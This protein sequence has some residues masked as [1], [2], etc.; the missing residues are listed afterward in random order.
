MEVSMADPALV[1]RPT[2]APVA[3]SRTD[4]IWFISA[5]TGWLVN[6][7]GNI[8]R[9]DD[10]G[11][12]WALQHHA[13][14]VYLRCVG[15]S[16]PQLGWVGSVSP[17]QRLFTT[18][19]GGAQWDVVG[20]LPPT[21]NKVCGLAVVDDQVIYGSGTNDPVDD[22]AILKT[23]DGGATWTSID[24][25]A[26][27][28]LLVDIH[29][30]TR[31]RGWVVGG[32]ADAAAAPA[33]QR[34]TRDMVRPVV[35]FTEDGG[36]TWTDLI[37]DK[38][39]FPHGEWGWKLF[40]LNDSVVFVSLENFR[41][42]AILKSIDGGKTWR[43]L[44]INDQQHNDNL[45]GVGFASD[46]I[47]WVGGWG[48]TSKTTNGG[49]NWA[50]AN[51]GQVGVHLNRFRFFGNPATL[52]YASGNTVYKYSAEPVTPVV[53]EAAAPSLLRRAQ[54]MAAGPAEH[55]IEIPPDAGSLS[56][57]LWD[58]FGNHLEVM[59]QEKP[60]AGEWKIRVDPQAAVTAGLR[61]GTGI[62]R[63]TI[64]ELTESTLMPLR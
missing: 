33:G 56:V 58:R 24:M 61:G 29:F 62:L 34:P 4:D 2:N 37:P 22:P 54:P 15:F 13:R 44:P 63:V 32:L 6:S 48:N 11:N 20:N 1:W 36:K 8:L 26:H 57:D 42:G 28:S 10:G 3:S 50:D 59:S 17:I 18:R 47:G 12:N 55:V 64:G 46:D 39:G 49:E 38:T 51:Q 30:A 41:A 53:V 31:D 9:T 25:T 52:G 23:T 16:N 43:R 60:A 27:A 7:N 21:P 14:R 35:L 19:N 40:F 45:E 5:D